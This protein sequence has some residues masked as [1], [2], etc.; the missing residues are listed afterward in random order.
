MTRRFAVAALLTMS[1]LLTRSPATAADDVLKLVPE[2]A[3]GLAVINRPAALDARLQSLGRT[4]K[5]PATSPL[6][7]LKQRLGIAEGWDENRS[8]A[9]VVLPSK[10]DHAMPTLV[11]LVPVTDYGRFLQQLKPENAAAETAEFKLFNQSFCARHIGGYAALASQSHREA[12]DKMPRASAEIPAALAPWREWLA[13]KD[14]AA[15]ILQPGIKRLSAQVQEGLQRAKAS[16]AKGPE[17]T[18]AMA[19]AFDMFDMYAKLFRAAEKEVATVGYGL[20]L[21]DQSALRL[22]NRVWLIPEGKWARV[23]AQSQPAKQNLLDGLPAEPFVVAVG[24]PLSGAMGEAMVKASANIMKSMPGVYGMSSEQI[25]KIAELSVQGMKGVRATSMLLAVGQ[26]GEPLF[27]SAVTIMQVDDSSSF[28]THYET[29]MKQYVELVKGVNNPMFPAPAVEKST[30]NGVSALQ[31]TVKAREPLA[32]QQAPEQAK[33]IKAMFGPEGKL[34]GW[35]APANEHAIVMSYDKERLLPTIE[36]I[37]QGKPGLAGDAEVSKTAALLPSN[38]LAIAYL[39][40]SGVIEY[41]KRLMLAIA[42][43][44]TGENLK[45]PEFPKTPPIGLAIT[46]TSNELQVYLVVPAEVFQAVGPYVGQIQTMRG[47]APAGKPKPTE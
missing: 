21:D 8:I 15:V 10:E 41:A 16:L 22:T 17:Q 11:L 38:T 32:G 14:V 29:W 36:A 46:T 34:V 30:V 12:L 47:S 28:L 23:L 40:P 4:M 19:G 45:L 44:G 13:E 25:D 7:M 26:S 33:M 6:A 42:P 24:M 2:G 35:I 9:L 37:K 27:S 18:K 20:Q 31:L 3:Y 5:L 43:H 39:S 1:L